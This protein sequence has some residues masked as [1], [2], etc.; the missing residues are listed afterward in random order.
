[1]YTHTLTTKSAGKKI[2]GEMDANAKMKSKQNRKLK[3]TT[4]IVIK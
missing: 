3:A 4:K 2:N 1:M